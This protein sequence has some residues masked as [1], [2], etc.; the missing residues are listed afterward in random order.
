[1]SRLRRSEVK[2]LSEVQPSPL[3][4]AYMQSLP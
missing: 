1:M 3:A 2:A 4:W